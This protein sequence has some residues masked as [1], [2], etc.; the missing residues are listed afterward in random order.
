MTIG[1]RPPLIGLTGR[2]I[3]AREL[4]TPWGF[5]DAP[6]DAYMS[7]Y[8]LCVARAGG[9]PVHLPFEIDVL[10]A[11][12]AM[13]ALV[14]TG[15]DDVDPQAYGAVVTGTTSKI[16]PLRDEFEVALLEAMM[17]LE[18]PVLGICR[19]AQLINVALGG[20]LI[21]HLPL[22]EGEAHS[23]YAYPRAHRRHRVDFIEGSAAHALYGGNDE[24]NSF[25]HQSVDRPG[26]GV[27]V[28]GRAPDGVVE[29][30]EVDGLDVLGVQWHPEC[31]GSDPAFTWVV[32]ACGERVHRQQSQQSR[33][34]V[35]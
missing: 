27:V 35:A 20:T 23:S 9:L 4:G 28:T 3:T 16:D 2:R 24:V 10:E 18:K 14:L 33:E 15:G 11:A 32:E 8:A 22:G 13:D 34:V 31:F 29:A 30:I 7:D 17:G 21:A 26:R 6:V 25:H 5:H 1:P 12:H 19:G